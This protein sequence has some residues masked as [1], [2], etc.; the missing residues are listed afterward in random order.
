MDIEG[1]G[2]ST[3]SS[4]CQKA[5]GVYRYGIQAGVVNYFWWRTER[6][7]FKLPAD[8]TAA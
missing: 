3:S 7:Y 4:S 6:S 2:H 8:K 1:Y 5:R